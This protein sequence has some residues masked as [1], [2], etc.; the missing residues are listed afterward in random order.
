MWALLN[1]GDFSLNGFRADSVAGVLLGGSEE[2]GP[3]FS[4][5]VFQRITALDSRA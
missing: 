4:M 1:L 5:N 3:P 2:A